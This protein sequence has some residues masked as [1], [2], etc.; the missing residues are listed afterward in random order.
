MT[1][2]EQAARTL[3]EPMPGH[4]GLVDCARYA[5][6]AA[7]GHNTQPWRFSLSA[8]RVDI[9]PDLSRRTPVVDPDDHHLWA[10]LGCAAENFLIAARAQSLHGD[11]RFDPADDGG[12]VLDLERG[13]AGT[14]DL[15]EAVPRRQCTRSD[16]DGRP[17]SAADLEALED[18]ARIDGV[19][20]VYILDRPRIETAVEH[21]VA[22]NTAQMQDE[23]FV[24]ELRQWLRFN[25]G[26]ALDTR[27]GLYAGAS[28]N[29]TLPGWLANLVFPLVF[30]TG[31]ENDKYARQI[32]SSSGMAVF[33]SAQDDRAHWV[34]A[35]RAYQRFALKATALGIANAFV[36]QPVEVPALRAEF[37]RWLDL[38][39]GERPDLVV[40]FGYAPPLPMSLRRPVDE[41]VD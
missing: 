8:R 38:E 41:V 5:T 22:G 24:A 14:D 27:D 32:R 15:F 20:I 33:V 34:K 16:H 9:R 3:R 4:A 10:S 23:A 25:D 7:N 35:G 39:G 2:Y 6:L 29:P 26:Q 21:V 1:D 37:A 31:S 28:G 17:V 11:V 13:P 30:R 18:A 40:R 12:L 36:N 19:R